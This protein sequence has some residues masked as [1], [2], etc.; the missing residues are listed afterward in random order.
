MTMTDPVRDGVSH[1]HGGLPTRLRHA[2]YFA[3]VHHDPQAYTAEPELAV[4]GLRAAA[5][6]APG[7]GPHLELGGTP[8]LLDQSLLRHG[9]TGSPVGTE[10]RTLPGTPYLPRW[11]VRL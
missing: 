3:R 9:A 7:I 2:R 5:P 8:L 6:L 4:H 10:S 11:C 1:G